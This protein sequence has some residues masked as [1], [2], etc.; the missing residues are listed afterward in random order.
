MF[1]TAGLP[2]I[3]MRFFTVKDAK[4]ARKSVF[5]ATGLIGYFYILTFIIGFGAIV[6]LMPDSSF[7]NVAA[8]GSYNKLTGLIGGSNMPA[9][10]AVEG[11]RGLVVLRLHLCSCLRHDP[12]GGGRPDAGGRQRGEP[13]PLRQRHRPRAVD[14]TRS[15]VLISKIT[16]V[17][18][19]IV[20]IVLGY[21]FEKVNVAFMVG[22]AFA[23][24]AS[25]NFPV[26]LMSLMWR[27][28]TT[29]GAVV[30]GVLGLVT[31]VG[32]VVLSKGVWVDVLGNHDAP[33]PYSS[34]ALFSM[35]LA[36]IGIYVVS[37]MDNSRR[38]Q[39]ERALFDQQ[40][41]RSETGI[42][43]SGAHAH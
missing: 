2:H 40:F 29:L 20:A 3:L 26:L 21:V 35:P 33:F 41:V 31:A 37:K 8:D 7:Y 38:A 43:A 6:F 32:M 36:F 5:Y 9:A 18:I 22:L 15:E 17:V 34:P 1:G 25:C 13:R 14:G 42:G 16:A 19:G 11:G 24:A 4:A 12:G 28:T 30:G 39:R 23:V 27:G 10:C